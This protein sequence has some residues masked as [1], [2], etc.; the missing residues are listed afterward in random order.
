[1]V[2]LAYTYTLLKMSIETVGV[3]VSHLLKR[4]RELISGPSLGSRAKFMTFN[5]FQSRVVT[6][7]LTG[8]NTLR[9]YL[10]LLGLHD[11]HLCR[12]CGVR[13]SQAKV[14]TG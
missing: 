10:H 11:S 14:L 12:K 4:L 7:L 1:M 2:I 13:A 5:M 9:R 3:Y 6:G 8:H